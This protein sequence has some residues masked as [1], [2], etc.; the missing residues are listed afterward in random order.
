M[1]TRVDQFL[2]I[3]RYHARHTYTAITETAC[4]KTLITETKA[5]KPA[6][7]RNE[8]TGT[9]EKTIKTW[10][11]WSRQPQQHHRYWIPGGLSWIMIYRIVSSD[12][13]ASVVLLSQ[14]LQFP[15]IKRVTSKDSFIFLFTT[16]SMSRNIKCFPMSTK[17]PQTTAHPVTEGW[18]IETTGLKTTS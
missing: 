7:H 3:R 1:Q 8:T 2:S 10:I 14:S 15:N 13:P 18:Q 6:K 5:T 17:R 16:Q 11:K 12:F 9:T 4:T